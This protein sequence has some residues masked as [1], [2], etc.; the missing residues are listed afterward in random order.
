MKVPD[1]ERVIYRRHQRR[2]TRRHRA[3]PDG[4]GVRPQDVWCEDV[5]HGSYDVDDPQHA[6]CLMDCRED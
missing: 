6:Q 2:R 1:A 4:S 3:I 5:C